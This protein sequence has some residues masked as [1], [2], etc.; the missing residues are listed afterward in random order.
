MTSETILRANIS[1]AIARY[2]SAVNENHSL[3]MDDP[4]KHFPA[5]VLTQTRLHVNLVDELVRLCKEN[6][7]ELEPYP[8][9]DAYEPAVAGNEDAI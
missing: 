2:T 6:A 9:P 7:Q 5:F 1:N 4:G 3:L 8:V